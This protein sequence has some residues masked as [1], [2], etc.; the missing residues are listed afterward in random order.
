MD[1]KKTIDSKNMASLNQVVSAF[2]LNL[3]SHLLAG[4][5]RA[6]RDKIEF[7][8]KLWV[9]IFLA[10]KQTQWS[11]ISLWLID[12]LTDWLRVKNFGR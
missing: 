3:S 1:I 9:I 12:Q 2:N 4:K 6:D 11:V 10:A 7:L 8:V 5:W